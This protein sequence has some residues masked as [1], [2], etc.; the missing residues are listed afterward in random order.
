M[1][2]QFYLI[3]PIIMVL[4]LGRA[5]TR[6]VADVSRWLFVAAVAIT[7]L[8]ALLST[9][10]RSGAVQTPDAYW[11]IGGRPISKLDTLYLSTFTRRAACCSVRRSRWCGGR[12]R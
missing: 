8:V 9:P 4:L 7:V 11:W 2:E 3:W 1:E 5:G 10:G 6:R 12:T